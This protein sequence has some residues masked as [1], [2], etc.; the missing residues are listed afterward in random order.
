MTHWTIDEAQMHLEEIF[1][2]ARQ[3][4]PQFLSKDGSDTAVL[5]SEA[6]FRALKA[7]KQSDEPDFLSFLLS[8]PKCDDFHIERELDT[9]RPVTT[10][11]GRP[12]AQIW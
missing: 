10:F 2:Q 6:D 12:A 9:G 3:G 5:I 11:H 7:G 4:V 8:G 1:D